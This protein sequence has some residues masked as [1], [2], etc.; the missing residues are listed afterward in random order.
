MLLRG[1]RDF[2][3][4][5]TY[6]AFLSTIK[7]R[8]NLQ[9]QEKLKEELPYLQ[10]L[11]DR[12]WRDPIT[13]TAR[14]SPS[15][16][17]QVLGCT[18]SVPSR[19]ISYTLKVQVYPDTVE[20][21]YGQKLLITM[22]RI[23]EGVLIDYRHIIDSL[24]RK[25]GAFAQYQYRSQLFPQP[26]FR[27]VYDQLIQAKP[28]TG[29]KSYLKILHLAKCYGESQVVAALHLAQGSQILP[30]EKAIYGYLQVEKGPCVESTILTPNLA[31]YDSLHSFGG[32]Q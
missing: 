9:R 21:Y 17:I 18:Y 19:F 10:A 26:I 3:D 7:E 31:A 24:I 6:E 5:T 20:L 28:E 27:I 2:A 22:P 16:T 1:S 15:S 11:P 32:C 13:F 29:H 12:G 30:D 8:R 14:V 4:L 23:N 25:P